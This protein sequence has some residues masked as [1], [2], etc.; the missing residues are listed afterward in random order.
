MMSYG[1]T[2]TSGPAARRGG[3]SSGSALPDILNAFTES[4]ACSSRYSRPSDLVQDLGQHMQP[5]NPATHLLAE[6]RYIPL[7]AELQALRTSTLSRTYM[8]LFP[9]IR[10]AWISI[11]GALYLWDYARNV[12]HLA[13]QFDMVITAVEC[14]PAPKDLFV[15]D[16]RYLLV[17]A[18]AGH[19]HVDCIRLTSATAGTAQS[20]SA[21]APT[22]GLS[23]SDLTVPTDGASIT[24][25]AST[26]SGRIFLGGYD[27]HVYE[28]DFVPA[29]SYLARFLPGGSGGASAGD[30]R[31]MQK[32]NRTSDAWDSVLPSIVT[33]FLRGTAAGPVRSMIVHNEQGWMAVLHEAANDQAAIRFVALIEPTAPTGAPGAPVAISA[34]PTFKVA[35]TETEIL[36]AAHTQAGL[37]AAAAFPA[38]VRIIG[39]YPVSAN[40][41]EKVHLV[42]VTSTSV[43]IYV[44]VD[45]DS[46][47]APRAASVMHIRLPPY[48]SV[49]TS[50]AAAA[51]SGVV[52]SG[53]PTTSGGRRPESLEKFMPSNTHV[54]TYARGMLLAS[55]AT[56]GAADLVLACALDLPRDAS[57][58]VGQRPPG[59]SGGGGAAERAHY[60]QVDGRILAL[61]EVDSESAG[62]ISV[63]SE[64][65]ADEGE[66]PRHFL[67]LNGDGLRV[68]SKRR[69]IDEIVHLVRAGAPDLGKVAA[70]YGRAQV[71]AWLMAIACLDMGRIHPTLMPAR[72]GSFAG[73]AGN[74]NGSGGMSAKPNPF[75][76]RRSQ[77]A[78]AAAA[79]SAQFLLIQKLFLA[80]GGVPQPM[81]QTSATQT[82]TELGSAVPCPTVQL[83]DSAAGLD[84]YLRTVLKPFWESPILATDPSSRLYKMAV[85]E[86]ELAI[87]EEKLV[88]VL[89]FIRAWPRSHE[90]HDVIGSRLSATG[91]PGSSIPSSA[92]DRAR[93]L[94]FGPQKAGDEA[95]WAEEHGFLDLRDQDTQLAL[96][97]VRYLRL[98]GNAGLP[99]LAYKFPLSKTA[100]PQADT[101]HQLLT[102][103]LRKLATTDDG[104]EVLGN[105]ATRVVQ[106]T[107]NVDPTVSSNTVGFAASIEMQCSKL[108]SVDDI[109]ATSVL[110][111]LQEYTRSVVDK[112][113]VAP[114]VW[115]GN[116]SVA[117]SPVLGDALVRALNVAGKLKDTY[118][119]D[120]A[121]QFQS[122]GFV[123]G[124]LRLALMRAALVDPNDVGGALYM[125][126]T[127]NADPR[128]PILQMRL[129]CYAMA[130][131]AFQELEVQLA[132]ARDSGNR[133]VEREL[134]AGRDYVHSLA[135]TEFDDAL[136][137]YALYNW[138]LNN[139]GEGRI[140]LHTLNTV[141]LESWLSMQQTIEGRQM[142][143][144][145]YERQGRFAD[146]AN[147][148]RG[149]ARSELAVPDEYAGDSIGG[150]HSLPER[151]RLLQ[152]ALQSAKA[153]GDGVL[154]KAVEDEIEVARVQQRLV[155]RLRQIKDV[156]E[157]VV[158]DLE[159]K[160]GL[161]VLGDLME[162]ASH[163]QLAD[164]RFIMVAIAETAADCDQH[165]LT[166]HWDAALNVMHLQ[167]PGTAQVALAS[168]FAVGGAV[169]LSSDMADLASDHA[170]YYASATGSPLFAPA[171]WLPAVLRLTEYYDGVLQSDPQWWLSV[172]THA[173][174]VDIAELAQELV[175]IAEA[176]DRAPKAQ[177][178]CD[179]AWVLRD[180]RNMPDAW[181]GAVTEWIIQ[182]ENLRRL[183]LA[184]S[185]VAAEVKEWIEAVG[186]EADLDVSVLHSS[187]AAATSSS[188]FHYGLSSSSTSRRSFVVGGGR[189][190]TDAH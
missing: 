160:H 183:A 79:L 61:A 113:A 186:Q 128:R 56:P 125:A 175:R 122:V 166:E 73:V 163:Y 165:M 42:L 38:G 120:I 23:D 117:K 8:G 97:A 106:L 152:Y 27:G 62:D 92:R 84:L 63:R 151:I 162:I 105:I 39:M 181:N 21:P 10:H 171:V 44:R 130:L 118:F 156:D 148:L 65:P 59:G 190:H 157:S 100:N 170:D 19:I 115:A 57:Y 159:S 7:P 116:V 114:D 86:H 174:V 108:L 180:W 136:W 17:V 58:L 119:A 188:S 104:R 133:H 124:V 40:E 9:A 51:R 184:H 25:I 22:I 78:V 83:S 70:V 81:A 90:S 102:R 150:A 98:L 149:A 49:S 140:K 41:S 121:K 68:I 87:A 95:C 29:R 48:D 129:Q 146:S 76:T 77:N 134:L 177:R 3:P 158:R 96:E 66:F 141:Y 137:H 60:L 139:E 112:G 172:A 138:Y 173:Q 46:T 135:V 89:A 154:I 71:C 107:A 34:V 167:S 37:H 142:L 47:Y 132:R 43:R 82:D 30:A 94:A 110:E 91:T 168:L 32:I 14:V 4:G 182:F 74:A 101:V 31:K 131:A 75:A 52:S 72:G 64:F 50:P 93:S 55:H 16:V 99:E 1:T 164:L 11:D 155:E 143:A 45:L 85:P 6:S 187:T 103:P 20:P 127:N 176:S 153:S 26:R 147:V 111:R 69:P 28:L 13:K 161:V 33:T 5:S 178:I 18:T 54:A 126:N 88:R 67:L 12:H 80:T 145:Y 189:F 36:R 35:L 24:A 123:T 185:D 15:D 53:V 2:G 109:F 169:Q 144:S 179:L